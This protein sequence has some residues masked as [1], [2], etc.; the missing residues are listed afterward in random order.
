MPSVSGTLR[1]MNTQYSPETEIVDYSLNLNGEKV[2]ALNALVGS[3][4][5]LEFRGAIHCLACDRLISKTFNNGY[6]YPC[7]INLAE[8]DSC[9]MQPEKCHFHLGTC[10]DPAWG[11]QHCFQK[12]TLYLARSSAIKIG[13][14]RS[15]Q[16]IHRW[17]DQGASEARVIGF[18]QDR[19]QV[20]LAEAVISKIMKD[21]TNWRKM[22]KNEVSD[23]DFDPYFEEILKVLS[24]EQ[25][26]SLISDGPSYAF[27][28]PVKT[29]PQKVNTKKLD[30]VSSIQGLLM[31]I[32]GQY[33]ILEDCV[34]NLRSHG[35]YHITFSY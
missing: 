35:G 25:C 2:L 27:S 9:I 3:E 18:F 4:I 32:K 23:D 26:A 24:E 31:G 34:I 28:Y 15:V 21:K 10:R 20:G 1:K 5:Q 17:M 6:C 19:Y 22:L 29:Y 11:E 13:I 33:L 16:Q 7:F 12:H 30:K 14:T 8:C